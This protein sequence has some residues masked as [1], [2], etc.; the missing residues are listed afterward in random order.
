MITFQQYCK[1]S[2]GKNEWK[3]RCPSEELHQ[4]GPTEEMLVFHPRRF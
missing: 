4:F 3:N 2:M 1:L